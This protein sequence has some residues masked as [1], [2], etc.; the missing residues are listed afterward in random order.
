MDGWM[1]R[2]YLLRKRIGCDRPNFFVTNRGKI[3]NQI[4]DYV[5][6]TFGARLTASIFRRMVETSGRDHGDATSGAIA[7]A[8]QH[9]VRTAGQ[10]YRLT[11]AKEALRRNQNIQ[12]VDHTAM[13]K[14]YVDKNFED[15][16][17][18]EPYHKF[19][20]D[21]WLAKIKESVVYREYPSASIDLYYVDQLGDR[22]TFP[23]SPRHPI[24]SWTTSS[25]LRTTPRL[26]TL[27][28]CR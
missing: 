15:L 2:N 13:V 4:Y 23:A 24:I 21:D 5:S 27:E 17:P 12:V 9:S 26:G 1:E 14:S 28:I 7:Q 10:Y 20:P 22:G 3:I 25:A 19:N 6:K 11:D 16:F 18:L 8:L